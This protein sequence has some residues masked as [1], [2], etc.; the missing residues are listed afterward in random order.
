M[1]YCFSRKNLEPLNGTDAQVLRRWRFYEISLVP[2]PRDWRASVVG[3]DEAE[4]IARR[5]AA[6]AAATAYR[7]QGAARGRRQA[8]L[9][10]F[11]QAASAGM[12]PTL[13]MAPDALLELLR[14]QAKAMEA[15]EA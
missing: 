6:D 15:A 4:E 14:A 10:P 11:M 5:L 1:G 8:V 2:L 3:G 13:G 7:Q 12:A 9:E